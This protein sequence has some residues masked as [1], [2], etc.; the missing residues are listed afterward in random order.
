MTEGSRLNLQVL[1]PFGGRMHLAPDTPAQIRVLVKCSHPPVELTTSLSEGVS[2][3][4]GQANTTRVVEEAEAEVDYT[5]VVSRIGNETE[6]IQ[7]RAEC[8]GL[9][10]L[11]D[12]VVQRTA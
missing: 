7:I 4:D 3:T 9:L 6:H 12:V 10:Q 2:L 8:G 1:E 11:A 5:V